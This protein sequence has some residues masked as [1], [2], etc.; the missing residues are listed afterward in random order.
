MRSLLAHRY[1]VN[2]AGQGVHFIADVASSTRGKR[3]PCLL[4]LGTHEMTIGFLSALY[5]WTK[6]LHVIS[7]IAWMAATFYMP[8]L[9][10]YHCE[11]QPGSAESERFKIMEYRLFKQIMNPAMI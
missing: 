2:W 11:L 8:R 1:A 4:F 3:T 6:A 10:V 7:M 5:P 9:F